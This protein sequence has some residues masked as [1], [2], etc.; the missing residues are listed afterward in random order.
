MVVILIRTS[1]ALPNPCTGHS[2]SLLSEIGRRWC[3]TCLKWVAQYYNVRLNLPTPVINA[4]MANSP[5]VTISLYLTFLLIEEETV[6]KQFSLYSRSEAI[7]SEDDK[8]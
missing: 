4:D 6:V 3:L 1:T 2:C 5:E 7:A 8:G